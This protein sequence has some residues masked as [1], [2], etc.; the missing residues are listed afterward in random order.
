MFKEISKKIE[1]LN[2][3][4]AK[5]LSIVGTKTEINMSEKVYNE[6]MKMNYFKENP[7]LVKYVDFKDD[8]LGRKNVVATLKGKKGS[9]NKTVIL[10]GH[11]DTVGIADFGKL[12]EFANDPVELKKK[13]KNVVLSKDAKEDIESE[14]WIFGRGIFDMKCGVATSIILI[15]YF[16]K[17]IDELQG[18]IIFAAVGDEEGNSDGMLSVVPELVK[19]QEKEG[20]EYQA[21][22]DNDYMT[23]RY[24]GDNNKYVYIGTVGKLMPSFY[25]VGKETHVG[26]P[27]KGIDPNQIASSLTTKINLNVEYCDIAEGEV[28]LPPITLKQN[29][30][31]ENYSVQTAKTANLYFNYSTHSNGPDEVMKEMKSAAKEAFQGVID[32]VEIQYKEFCKKSGFP[33]RE[34][35]WVSRV[36]SYQ[37]LY[38]KVYEEMGDS[39][40]TEIEK[41][42]KELSKND[43]IDDRDYSLKIVSEVHKLWSDNDPIIVVYFSPPYY[44]HIYVRGKNKKEKNLLNAV[45]NAVD[46][47]DTE[48]KIVQKKF[49]PYIS[50]LSYV[51]A[52]KD[53]NVLSALKNNMPALGV[54]YDL[55][56]KELQKLNLPVVNIGPF[57]KDAHKL[58][59]RLEKRYSYNVAPKIVCETIKNILK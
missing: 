39:L 49:Y 15:E 12:R 22:I 20:Y 37:E 53:E 50:D 5:V 3:E 35:P 32:N 47:I 31:K 52:P 10:I 26:E 6:L 1:R 8:V 43:F 34:L 24:E 21:V 14:D 33:H 48:D 19:M 17:K 16:S 7:D 46:F 45:N 40:K 23:E 38:E 11:M 28:S 58:T 25:I 44:P 51:S 41:L 36:I 57:G 55:P 54:K 13:L 9:S 59:E 29:D 18:N 42:E 2:I 30:L 56:L 27:Y 4:L